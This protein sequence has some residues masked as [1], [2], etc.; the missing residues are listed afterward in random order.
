M[1]RIRKKRRVKN[2]LRIFI[3][4]SLGPIDAIESRSES[5][6]VAAIAK[7]IGHAVYCLP[8]KSLRELTEAC[9]YIGS[10]NA[11]HDDNP[12]TPLCVHLSAHGADDGLLFGGDDVNWEMLLNVI[13][14]VL[15]RDYQGPRILVLSSCE[16]DQQNL[17]EKIGRAVKKDK[18]LIPPQYIFCAP[19]KIG[20]SKAAVGWTVIYHL[21]PNVN[22][23]KKSEVQRMLEKIKLV[24]GPS[25]HFS[26]RGRLRGR[27]RF[28]EGVT[29]RNAV[30]GP[31]D[32]V[33][34]R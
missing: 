29:R 18:S 19:G 20:W 15:S 6:G 3:V 24:D 2:Y 4:E 26:P 28:L 17:T 27:P 5:L 7:L 31:L 10:I 23:D 16:A 14:P 22:L 8:C 32:D 13:Q 34:E 12:K 21:I 30:D 11:T 9:A 1:K 33:G 25:P